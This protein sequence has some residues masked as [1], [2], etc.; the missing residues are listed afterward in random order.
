VAQLSGCVVI[1]VFLE[2]IR[3]DFERAQLKYYN[4]LRANDDDIQ[5]DDDDYIT[6]YIINYHQIQKIESYS[7]KLSLADGVINT[8]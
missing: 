5:Y 6:G 4:F 7:W 2:L 3:T 8:R 1:E